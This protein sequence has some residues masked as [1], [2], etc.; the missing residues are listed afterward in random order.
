MNIR[1]EKDIYFQFNKDIEKTR[2]KYDRYSVILNDVDVGFLMVSQDASKLRSG[3]FTINDFRFHFEMEENI[4]TQVSGHS[5]DQD[6]IEK[7]SDAS[8]KS[9]AISNYVDGFTGRLRHNFLREKPS[10]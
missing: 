10:P 1:L 8:V 3:F 4:S 7:F 9:L 2:T 5:Y 6:W